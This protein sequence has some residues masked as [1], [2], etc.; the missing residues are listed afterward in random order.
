M[1]QEKDI[2]WLRDDFRNP[3]LSIDLDINKEAAN[4]LGITRGLLGLS[5][6]LNR[7]GMT[8]AT[9]WE[10]DYQKS[11]VLKY[12]KSKTSKPEDLG[13]QYVSA[14]ICKPIMLRQLQN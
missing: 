1:Q 11:V 5:T 4:R 12:D 6:A 3:L 8:V 2:I 13:R 14:P 9:I 7:N 10:S